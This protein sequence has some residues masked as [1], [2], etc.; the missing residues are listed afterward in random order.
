VKPIERIEYSIELLAQG[1]F[2]A[3][4]FET[5]N[6]NRASACQVGLVVFTNGREER[7]FVSLIKPLVPGFIHTSIHGIGH[8]QVRTAPGFREVYQHIANDLWHLP[9]V[10]HNMPFDFGVLK[11][12]LAACHLT[13]PIMGRI[14]TLQ[15]SKQALAL[16]NYRLS[17]VADH[18]SL[19][20]NHHEALSDARACGNIANQLIGQVDLRRLVKV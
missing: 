3:F 10:A 5:A 12:C 15:A 16:P 1:H 2:V 14:C 8:E 18:F 17:T 13:L 20:L 6:N 11:A 4:D 9:W 19:P 7:H